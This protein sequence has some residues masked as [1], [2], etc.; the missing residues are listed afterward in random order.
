MSFHDWM[1]AVDR[2]L[3]SICGFESADLADQTYRD[4]HGDGFSPF[5]AALMALE[6]EGFPF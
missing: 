2:E 4:W 5:E 3:A 6:N 1:R